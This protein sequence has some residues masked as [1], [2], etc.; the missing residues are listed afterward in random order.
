MQ[1]ANYLV[2]LL[3]VFFFFPVFCRKGSL[4]I[5][6]MYGRNANRI[7]TLANGLDESRKRN[8]TLSLDSKWSSW[9][10]A[11][12]D[13]HENIETNFKGRCTVTVH[14]Q[15]LYTNRQSD[16]HNPELLELK[17]KKK[18][19]RRA[20][21]EF[22]KNNKTSVTV[23]RRWLEGGCETK[24]KMREYFCRTS[25]DFSKVCSW[26]QSDIEDQLRIN[27]LQTDDFQ[28]DSMI[29][30]FTDNQMPK[31][32]QTFKNPIK[33][34]FQV[35]MCMMALSYAHFGS[36][37]S[38]IDYVVAHWRTGFQFPTECFQQIHFQ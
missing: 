6:R 7:I 14:A 19:W 31:Y 36:P 12:F 11:W 17:P 29:L 23:H 8:L 16:E 4:C 33:L 26:T 30:L 38:S 24:A 2:L 25:T 27:R 3:Q 9:Y 22:N 34:K 5:H 28:Q 15:I 32:D 35:E 20:S 18:Y 1:A 21:H 10:A 13:V 37:M